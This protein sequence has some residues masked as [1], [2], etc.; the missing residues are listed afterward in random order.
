MDPTLSERYHYRTTYVQQARSWVDFSVLISA[1]E[2]ADRIEVS[3]PPS[4]P[5][6]G[7]SSSPSKLST[8]TIVPE[9]LDENSNSIPLINQLPTEILI[10]IFEESIYVPE[11][12]RW[13]IPHIQKLKC[14]AS[15]CLW[16]NKLIKDTPHLWA[17]VESNVPN[18]LVP[19]IL[20][21]SGQSTLAFKC[22]E[23]VENPIRLASQRYD[24]EEQWPSD[25]LLSFLTTTLSELHRWRSALFQISPAN[26]E[27]LWQLEQPAPLIEKMDF[28][29][30]HWPWRE[31]NLFSGYAPNLR[32]IRIAGLPFIWSQG[33][34][35]DLRHLHIENIKLP[36]L[37]VEDILLTVQSSPNL[38]TLRLEL[39][40]MSIVQTQPNF[41]EF[42]LEFLEELSLTNMP[43]SAT[44]TI[45]AH[46]R[47]PHLRCL[48]V[49]P[50]YAT[51]DF[52]GLKF[53]DTISSHFLPMNHLDLGD[54]HRLRLS[55]DSNLVDIGV[56]SAT[57]YSQQRIGIRIPHN[58]SLHIL[59]TIIETIIHSSVPRSPIILFIEEFSRIAWG[60]LCGILSSLEEVVALQ[61][62][63]QQ[64][65]RQVDF[66]KFLATPLDVCG[67]KKWL[68][69]K[70]TEIVLPWYISGEQAVQLV[71]AR[72]NL[73][74]LENRAAAQDG[75]MPCPL[76]MLDVSWAL[77]LDVEQLSE[78]TNIVGLAVIRQPRAG[79]FTYSALGSH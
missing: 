26:I 71:R 13:D 64:P 24:K 6:T 69:P 42:R 21:K 58:S 53:I 61:V 3:T 29:I 74:T 33:V 4:Q 66:F 23:G 34:F 22:C 27:I 62:W 54:S 78:I 8:P 30:F 25:D 17:V 1:P 20:R 45:L 28:Q 49:D 75:A 55:L 79:D 18:E 70:L 68:F 77:N 7:S 46:I 9:Q 37:A 12:S 16:W 48:T 73:G 65:D 56:A 76:T 19:I 11:L 36:Q 39:M 35:H 43:P 31:I 63:A 10:T 50:N 59:Q 5:S 60:D 40:E 15:V 38:Q 2:T 52:D 57:D 51:D 67:V 44:H 47:A 72:Y 41:P 32:W 14:L